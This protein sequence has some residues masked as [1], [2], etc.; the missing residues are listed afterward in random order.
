MRLYDKV[1]GRL[2]ELLDL[3]DQTLPGIPIIEIYGD[4]RVLIEGRCTVVQYM[5]T[6]IIIRN[7]CGRVCICGQCLKMVELSKDKMIIT[8]CIEGISISGR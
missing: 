8:G 7:S 4:R 5:Q 3:P 2:P 6:S 1:R